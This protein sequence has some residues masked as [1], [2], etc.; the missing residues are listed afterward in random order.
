MTYDASTTTDDVVKGVDL[1]GRTAVVTGAS[2]GLGQETA[3][4]LA[5]V[6]A[7]VVMAVR[8]PDKGNAAAEAIRSSVPDASLEVGTLDLAALAGVRAFSE[9][10]LDRHQRIDLLINNAGVMA[11]P[12][13]RT[14]DGFELQLGTNHLG[15]FLLTNRVMD[16]VLAGAP[17][18]IV[19]LSS[20]G[21]FRSAFDWDDPHYRSRPYE[22]WEGYGQ[23]KTANVLFTVELERRYAAR[24]VHAYAIHP[25]VIM[26]ELSRHLSADDYT[27]LQ[28]RLPA[29]ALALKPVEAGAATTVWAAT[30]PE[31]ADVGGVYCEDCHVAGPA[32]GDAPTEGY[33]E[34]A[35][36]S[37]QAQR[38][39]TW[40]EEQVGEKFGSGG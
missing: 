23:S 24:G 16:A 38:L 15:H 31:L 8:D 20:R 19:N 36:D 1:S 9:W 26:T 18:R 25:G 21:H 32:T 6:G 7:T 35:M 3:R 37:D 5:S 27:D 29:G 30:S 14:A 34:W 39:W 22:K 2:S 4:S 28:S 12:L 10:L 11:P 33:R 40:S 13:G 17:A